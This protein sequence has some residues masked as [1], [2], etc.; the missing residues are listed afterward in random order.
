MKKFITGFIIGFI[1]SGMIVS[2]DNISAPPPIKDANIFHYFTQ[3]YNN[4]HRLQVVSSD[5]DASR[6][7]KKGDML[8]YLTGGV[9]SFCVNTDSSTDWDCTVLTD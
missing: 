4:F 9:G 7:G 1:L 3:I 6:N 8:F 5:P 2:A